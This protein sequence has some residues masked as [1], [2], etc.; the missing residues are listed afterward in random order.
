MLSILDQEKQLLYI[1]AACMYVEVLHR[2]GS[3]C[4]IIISLVPSSI[5]TQHSSGMDGRM[6]LL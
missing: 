3:F 4:G 6:S 1:Y 2:N 5:K